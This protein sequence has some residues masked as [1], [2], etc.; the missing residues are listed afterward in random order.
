[1]LTSSSL[2]RAAYMVLA[3]VI[4]L[5]TCQV[6]G[7]IGQ[8]H[9]KGALPI[10]VG[11]MLQALAFGCM[12]ALLAI[13][14]VLIYRA[15]RII[16]FAHAGFGG[17]AAILFFELTGFEGWP[18]WA[19][20]VVA[21][22]AAGV[23]GFAMELFFIRRFGKAARLVLT[24]V[25][26]G[27]G[28][29]LAGIAGLVP[30]LLRDKTARSAVPKTPFTRFHWK[31]FPVVLNGNYAVL[32]AVTVALLVAFVL[33]FR[34]TSIG[35]AVRG[36]AE[37]DDRASLLGINTKNLASLV[38]VIAAA[39]AGVAYVLQVPITG[40]TA[41]ASGA[42]G[43]LGSG[44]LL[45]ALTA[46]VLGG[47]ENLPIAVVASLLIAVFESSV[48]FAFSQTAIVDAAMVVVIVLVLLAQRKKLARTE[49]SGAG[50][51]AATEEIRPIPA[52]LAP[53][54][55][56]RSGK[57]R[58]YAMVGLFLLAFP[59]FMSPAQTNLGSLFAIY[60]IIVV[61]L[62]VLTGWGGQISLG[63]F[64]FV[65][66]GAMAGGSL[67]SRAHWPF[68]LAL[69]AGS[70]IGAGAAVLLGLPALRI[71][72]LFL[73]VTTLGFAVA[74]STVLLNQR[75]FGAILPNTVNRPKL[76]WIRFEDERAYYY[77]CLLGLAFAVAA[78]QGIRHSRTGRVLI[79]MRDNER[80]AQAFGVN[81][82][83]TRLATFAISG[84]L[85]AFAGV[86][87]ASH[88][89]AVHQTAFTAD[90][91]IQLF[92]MAVIGGL[93]SVPGAL[94]GA[95]YLGVLN[96]VVH[97]A[98]GRL[99]GSSF[100]VLIVLMFFPGG[101]GA[102]VFKAR[103]SVLRRIA[104]RRRIYVPSLLGQYGMVGGQMARVPL[105]PKFGTDGTAVKVP[106]R[107]RR[108]SRIGAAGASQ[109]ARRWSY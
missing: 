41:G 31:V 26:I 22:A 15:N 53:L 48:F 52:E 4:V 97:G 90:Q 51:W 82:V 68:V 45:R 73:A 98:V 87:F 65:A 94:F 76:V 14:I 9:Y 34:F 27:V 62:V 99:L 39:S 21:V 91:S 63:Q 25:T 104:I 71:R 37:N 85:A 86:L 42:A 6:L 64:A 46:A 38:W 72:G 33:F 3:A 83:R 100:G 7:L 74:A 96:I 66:V 17:V 80:A 8:K 43:G 93:G 107:Y 108:P 54:P 28:Q 18:Y 13:G 60:G 78:A 24:V 30:G 40:I 47:M 67:I 29:L 105:A 19:A 84:F 23:L 109:S 12:N 102:L 58:L 56:V 36:A 79:A 81:L 75:Y 1:M 44:L 92:L 70:A 2:K 101:L 5:V 61:S 89:H 77:L 59:W 88:Q 95:I 49:D 35:I 106:V 50:T 57:R 55:S 32:A 69:I 16:N 11:V 20:A 103:D 10:P